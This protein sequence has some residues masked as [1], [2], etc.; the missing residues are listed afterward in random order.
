[1]TSPPHLD[2]T[3]AGA[4]YGA[5]ERSGPVEHST[6]SPASS[7]ELQPPVQRVST[8]ADSPQKT[9]G[10]EERMCLCSCQTTKSGTLEPV[11]R[12]TSKWRSLCQ[13]ITALKTKRRNKLGLHDE[14]KYNQNHNMA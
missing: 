13:Y 2:G 6:E 3:A 11:N 7:S 4:V 1:M 5:A 9:T 14:S 12:F 8:H 10:G